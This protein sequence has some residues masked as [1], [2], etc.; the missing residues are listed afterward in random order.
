LK[1]MTH[2]VSGVA[3][4]TFIPQVVRISTSARFAVEGAAGSF[5]IVLAGI[6]GM[7]PDTLDFK[8]NQFFQK[9]LF[10]VDPEPSSPDPAEIAAQFARAVN[11]AGRTGKEVR[12]QFF[13]IQ[14]SG[15]E[16]RQY[17]IFFDKKSVSVQVNEI[18]S[19]SQ[20]PVPGTAPPA[21]KRSAT[22][23]FD[24]ELKPR[25]EK[26]DWLNSSV[27]LLRRLIKG[28]DKPGKKI[29][30]TTV[31]ILSS[32]MFGLE[33]EPDGRVYFNWLPWHRTWTHSY[34]LGLILSVPVFL[35]AYLLGVENWSLYG[36]VA[37]LG[38]AVHLT[39]D[40]TGHIGGSILWPLMRQRTEGLELFKASDPRTNFSV[41]YA[42]F[43]LI[44]FNID[45]FSTQ[46]ITGAPE[47]AISWQLFLL[48]FLAL[49]LLIYFS[50]MKK[51]IAAVRKESEGEPEP[52]EPDGTGDPLID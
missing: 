11:E 22:A 13:P 24:Y 14:L 34:L 27:R 37:F 46:L 17:C 48:L 40:M 16:W 30:P 45:R 32:T 21:D 25:S 28:P 31:D 26:V 2:F 19:T 4:A 18:V 29:P 20:I 39:E 49:P 12:I 41:I 1:G 43:I 51:I 9:P 35:G 36:G 23:E 8:F 3:A 5:I 50:V 38:F 10:K 44:I 15:N 42:A 6:F 33:K 7:L 47:S 52:E